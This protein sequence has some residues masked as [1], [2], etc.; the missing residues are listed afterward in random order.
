MDHR[1]EVLK[2]LGLSQ[3][4]IDVYKTLSTQGSMTAIEILKATHM[5]RPTLYYSIRQLEGRGLLHTIPS[6]G[7]SRYQSEKPEKLITLLAMREEELRSLVR[8][9][10]GI[11]PSLRQDVHHHEGVP[12]VTF[13]QGEENM[14]QAILDTLYCRV[15]H[16]DIL[17]P[18]DN[19]FWQTGQ[20]FSQ[21]YIDERVA[22]KIKTRHLWEEALPSPVLKK[23]YHQ[24]ISTI[25]ILPPSMRGKFR[26]A[27]FLFDQSVMYISSR[28]SGYVLVVKSNEHYEL[29][30]SFYEMAWT[31]SKELPI[32]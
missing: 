26:T 10:S 8:E 1:D 27:V 11:I 29:M 31:S 9:V 15:R 14:K 24:D 32:L 22:R 19:F 30:K 12:A 17:T 18:K 25:R 2:K 6:G 16:I 23:S 20:P 13:Y 3:S 28:A 5:K 4:E 21:K 7:V